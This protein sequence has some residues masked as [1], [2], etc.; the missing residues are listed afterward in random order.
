MTKHKSLIFVKAEFDGKRLS[1]ELIYEEGGRCI[2]NFGY[3]DKAI[4]KGVIEEY[5]EELIIPCNK[6]SI[7]FS[8]EVQG[9]QTENWFYSKGMQHAMYFRE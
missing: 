9:K 4:Y 1:L 3:L 2:T 6:N 7:N 8:M 5:K